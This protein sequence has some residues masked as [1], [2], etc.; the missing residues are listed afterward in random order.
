MMGKATE[1]MSDKEA[2]E[3]VAELATDGIVVTREQAR[4]AVLRYTEILLLVSQES[5]SWEEE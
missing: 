2:D 3:L 1:L 4:D 5:A